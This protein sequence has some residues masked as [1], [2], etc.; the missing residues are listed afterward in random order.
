MN[1]QAGLKQRN[2]RSDP[3]DNVQKARGEGVPDLG[4]VVKL[5]ENMINNAVLGP[6]RFEV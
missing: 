2:G 4:Y 5:R 6:S 3:M 1:D